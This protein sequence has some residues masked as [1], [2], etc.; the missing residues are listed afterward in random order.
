M[1]ISAQGFDAYGNSL[2]YPLIPV[3]ISLS[4]GYFDDAGPGETERTIDSLDASTFLINTS[5]SKAGDVLYVTMSTEDQFADLPSVT[6]E[7]QLVD[8]NFF[9]TDKLGTI[10]DTVNYRLPTADVGFWQMTSDGEAVIRED[11]LISLYIVLSADDERY[12]VSPVAVKSLHGVVQPGRMVDSPDG[13]RVFVPNET[14]LLGGEPLDIALFPSTEAGS[15]VLEIT[16]PGLEKLLIP[17]NVL[18]S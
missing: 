15:D 6:Q 1:P 7:V 12:L 2:D 16:L 18:P 9:V 8:Y 5:G 14:Y 10:V 3:T 4:G 13:Q 11:N 17:I